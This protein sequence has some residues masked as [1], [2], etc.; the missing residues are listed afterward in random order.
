MYNRYVRNDNGTYTRI[1]EETQI[2]PPS[3]HEV[4]A[5]HEHDLSLIH[6]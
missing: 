3:G 1:P 5:H 4:H 2:P 6:I